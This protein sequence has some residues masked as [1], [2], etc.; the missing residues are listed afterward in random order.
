MVRAGTNVIAIRTISITPII[1]MIFFAM[2][3]TDTLEM[4]EAKKRLQP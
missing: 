1:G 2:F 3:V 4:A